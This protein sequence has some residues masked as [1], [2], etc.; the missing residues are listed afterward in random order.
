VRLTEK[1]FQKV[2]KSKDPMMMEVMKSYQVWSK[3]TAWAK[4]A[5]KMSSVLFDT[6][7]IYLSFSEKFLKME[8]IGIKINRGYTV[9]DPGAKKINVATEWKDK[10]AFLDLLVKRLIS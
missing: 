8:R 9:E 7:A 3:G 10:N 5:K 2:Y 1:R 4:H 6:V